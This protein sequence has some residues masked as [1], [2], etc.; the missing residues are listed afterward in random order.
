M[1]KQIRH[2]GIIE[3]VD[4]ARVSVRIVQTS[5][6][7]GCKVASHCHTAEAKEKVIEVMEC[8]NSHQ[9]QVGQPVVVTASASIAGKG[10]LLA[11]GLPLLLMLAVL[12]AASA[13]HASEGTTAL[14]MLASL[15]PYYIIIW[16]C[17]D[18]ISRNISFRIEEQTN[19]KQLNS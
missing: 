14:L 18:R 2:E 9:W 12:V 1:E 6:C 10:L 11:F 15:V 8:S 13:A 7:A 19:Y 17:R 5:A 4:G 16:L 3:A